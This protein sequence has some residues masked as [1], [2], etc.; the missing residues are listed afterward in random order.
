MQHIA[1][2][3][4]I[5]A[6]VRRVWSI[7]MDFASYPAW[8]PFVRRLLGRPEPGSALS[9][10][11]QLPGRAM[12]IKPTVLLQKP[13]QEFR[14]KGRLFV[15]GLFDG[16]HCFVL[17]ATGESAT[18]F[19]HEEFFTGLLV[20]L[21]MRGELKA[22]TIAGFEAMNKALKSRAEAADA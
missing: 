1:T 14:W 9:V 22:G 19:V 3:I 15:P 6:P 8:N 7:L 4:D 13:G 10:T 20:P 21:V 17:S 12:D 5:G 16:E 18:R 2:A 11:L